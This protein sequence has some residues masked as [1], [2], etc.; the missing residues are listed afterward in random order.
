M[1]QQLADL[2]ST[3][4]EVLQE[5]NA[6]LKTFD[7]STVSTYEVRP[8][9]AKIDPA[10]GKPSEIYDFKFDRDAMTDGDGKQLGKYQ[11]DC[12]KGQKEIYDETVGEKNVHKV[13][14]ERCRCKS[15]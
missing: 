8:D 10:T 12:Q 3:G 9:M 6:A 11:D 7:P 14:N 1:W 2:A 5:V 15:K 4:Y 13:D